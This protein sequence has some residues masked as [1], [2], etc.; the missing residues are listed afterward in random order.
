MQLTI[1]QHRNYQHEV[2]TFVNYTTSKTWKETWRMLLYINGLQEASQLD[3]YMSEPH[4]LMAQVY[5]KMGNRE[6]AQKELELF[7]KVKKPK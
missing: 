6:L 2:T 5:M 7:K 3:P 1:K 4:Y